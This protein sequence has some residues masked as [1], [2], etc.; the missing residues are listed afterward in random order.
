MVKKIVSVLFG[1]VLVLAILAGMGTLANRGKS[2]SKIPAPASTSSKSP[3]SRE[4]KLA[5]DANTKAMTN[6]V[7]KLQLQLGKRLKTAKTQTDIDQINSDFSKAIQNVVSESNISAA[8]I[9]KKFG[10]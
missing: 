8:K 4:L 1:I 3:I 9:R 7:N 10:L 5:L 2:T 6:Q